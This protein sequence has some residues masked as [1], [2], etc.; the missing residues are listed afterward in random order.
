MKP[1][2]HSEDKKMFSLTRSEKE[3]FDFSRKY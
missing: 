1:V 3:F 2:D